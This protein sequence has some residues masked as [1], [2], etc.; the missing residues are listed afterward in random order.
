MLAEGE[1]ISGFDLLPGDGYTIDPDNNG[2]VLLLQ[3]YQ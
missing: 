2:S 3:I 1:E